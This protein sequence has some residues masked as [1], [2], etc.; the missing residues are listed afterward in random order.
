MV[1]IDYCLRIQDVRFLKLPN[2][3]E[4]R[5]EIRLMSIRTLAV[6]IKLEKAVNLR[7]A[8]VRMV[9]PKLGQCRTFINNYYANMHSQYLILFWLGNKIEK[10]TQEHLA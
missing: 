2:V 10:T 9:H 7:T 3:V 6:L 1:K 4:A 8:N 5:M